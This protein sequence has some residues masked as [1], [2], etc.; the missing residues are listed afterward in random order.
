MALILEIGCDT[1]QA[2]IPNL[3]VSILRMHGVSGSVKYAEG[4]ITCALDETHPRLQEALAS[5]EQLLPPSV[6]MRGSSH[7]FGDVPVS[8]PPPFLQRLPLGMGVC[9]RCVREMFDPL[10]RRYYYPFTSCNHCGG[11]YAFFEGYPYVRQNT[12]LRSLPPCPA[13]EQELASDPFREG[14]PQIGCHQCAVTVTWKE[15]G[16]SWPAED[17]AG[18]KELF[19]KAAAAV[20]GGK[21]VRIKTTMGTRTFSLSPARGEESVIMAFDASKITALF[22]LIDEEFNA[23]LSIERPILHVSLREESLR[24]RFGETADAQYPDDG[25]CLLLGRELLS[26]GID[27]VASTSGGAVPADIVIDYD[28]PINTQSPMRLFL[29]K[30]VRFIARG[31]RGSFPCHVAPAVDVAGFAHGLAAV[32][33]GEQM[34]ID[35]PEHLGGTSTS[36]VNALSGEVLEFSHGNLHRFDQDSASFMAVLAENGLQKKSAVCAYFDE[37]ITFLYARG[38]HVTRV[39]PFEPF[40][41]EGLIARLAS[42]R[43]GSDRLVDNLRMRHQELYKTLET[44]ESSSCGLFEAAAM[45]MGVEGTG[46]DALAKEALRFIGKGGLQIDTKLRDN[47]FDSVAFLASIISYR[48]ADVPT[49]LLCYSVFE[50]LGD[51]FSDILTELKNRAK[52]EHIAVCGSGFANQSL[53]SRMA[54]NLKHTP[55]VLARSFPIGRENGVVGGIYL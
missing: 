44:I 47:R 38:G 2:T 28:V 25:F 36:K 12:A 5:M 17:A 46:T 50:S 11:Q 31:E 40:V 15:G 45:I 32:R 4:V 21:R 27:A 55:P 34:L 48:V 1:H 18:F 3:L 19:G 39:I 24:S 49:A 43:E 53:Y 41:S 20:A 23:L 6:F 29:N 14:Y 37:A 22:S 33:I 13:C 42:L 30:E 16:T 7:R 51:Y 35:R 9:P 26:L 8:Q 10:S 52:A 54:R